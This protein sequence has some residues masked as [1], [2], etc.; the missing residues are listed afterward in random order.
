VGVNNIIHSK[1]TNNMKTSGFLAGALVGVAAGLL[2]APRTGED[3]RNEMADTAEKWKN[4]FA[5]LTGKTAA[6]LSDLRDMLEYE[7]TGLSDDV[8]YRLLTI[9]EESEKSAHKMKSAVAAELG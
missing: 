1:K 9:L 7:V 6:E 4:K 2:L 3:L 5:K 8:R